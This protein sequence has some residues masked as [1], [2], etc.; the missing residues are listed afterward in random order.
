MLI[1]FLLMLDQLNGFFID[2]DDQ[3]LLKQYISREL[4]LYIKNI[5]MEKIVIDPVKILNDN[6]WWRKTYRKQNYIFK[7]YDQI[8]TA[9]KK[10]NYS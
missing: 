10:I 2:V 8:I 9:I 6:K 5:T 3:M 4:K 7:S 1:G